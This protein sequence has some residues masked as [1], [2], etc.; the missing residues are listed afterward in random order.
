MK[1]IFALIFAALIIFSFTACKNSVT[2]N[3]GVITNKALEKPQKQDKIEVDINNFNPNDGYTYGVV[4]DIPSNIQG[5]IYDL[6]DETSSNVIGSI[7]VS[8][9]GDNI[10]EIDINTKDCTDED[11][12]SAIKMA[13]NTINSVYPKFDAS[14]HPDFPFTFEVVKSMIDANEQSSNCIYNEDSSK[15]IN[16]EF[17]P[18]DG[19][20]TFMLE[21]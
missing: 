13:V 20:L 16:Y 5:E 11:L 7:Y 21:Y 9:Q 10:V 4:S 1:R 14:A 17:Y 12:K 18:Q 6:T 3:D 8:S 15:T 19:L 2:N